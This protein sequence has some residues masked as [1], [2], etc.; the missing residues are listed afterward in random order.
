MTIKNLNVNINKAA[1]EINKIDPKFIITRAVGNYIVEALYCDT[2]EELD[3]VIRS[4][5]DKPGNIRIFS[6]KEQSVEVISP[7]KE[8]EWLV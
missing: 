5:E 7:D 3:E 8:N 1:L 4:L 6:S 2:K